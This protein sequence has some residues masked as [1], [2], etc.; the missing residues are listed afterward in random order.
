MAL[1]WLWKDKCGEALLVQEYDGERHEFTLS[2][3]EG[4]AELIMLHEYK[5]EKGEN[6]YE[7][8]AFWVDKGHMKRCLGLEANCDG[9]KYNIHSEG[10]SK[11]EKFRFNKA[12]SRHYKEIIKALV[13]AFDEITIEVFTEADKE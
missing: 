3:Y 10:W 2:L 1:N 7:M 9:T 4:N 6:M 12:K 8:H 13:E 11:I 5:N